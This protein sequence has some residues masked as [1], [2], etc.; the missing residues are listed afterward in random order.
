MQ[1]STTIGYILIL[2][3]FVAYFYFN[4]K[5]LEEIEQDQAQ[6]EQ[7]DTAGNK[8]D[9]I[10]VEELN[11]S[12]AELA[13]ENRVEKSF[14]I[15]NDK[16]SLEVLNY[17]GKP[18]KVELKEFKRYDST[19]LILFEKGQN[20]FNF[21]IPLANGDLIKTEDLDFNLIENTTTGDEHKLVVRAKVDSLRSIT[22][23]YILKDK[24]YDIDYSV[25]FKGFASIISPKSKYIEL[26]WATKVQAQE[27]SL[28]EERNT[29]TVYYK[30][31][32]EKGVDYLKET[33]EDDENLEA[34]VQWISFKQKFFNATLI[35]RE[36][37]REKGFKIE[38]K[39][40]KDESYIEDLSANLYLD[41]KGSET[42][43]YNWSL[44]YGPNHYQTLKKLD[45]G[46]QKIIP[47]GWGIFGWVNK[48]LVIPVF[49]WLEQYISN[50]GLIILCLTL[51]IKL[52]LV[53]PMFKTYLSSA[54]MRLLKPEL[55]AIKEKTG[56][57]MQKMQQEQMKLYKQAG[58]SP[59][60]G[61]LPQLVQLPI[62]FAMFRFFPAS[63]ELRQEKLWWADDLSTYDSIWDFPGGFE[64]PFYGDHV[65]LFTLL[66]TIVT[67]IYTYMNS[68]QTAGMSGPM[69]YVM[70]LMPIMFLGFFNNYSAALSFYYF[71]STCITMLQNVIIRKFFIDEDKL[72][73][74]LQENKKKKVSVKKSGLQKRLEEMAKKRGVDPYKKPAPKK[75]K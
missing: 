48:G 29:T 34:D 72:H 58:V 2:G 23:T 41:V 5:T 6:I 74:Q 16:L 15:E 39:E 44:Y 49:N 55:D 37:F 56:G 61:C 12:S 25:D 24:K 57:D 64:I 66:M 50:Y 68:Q 73:K 26:L 65:S 71:L 33:S 59:L 27:R 38:T 22:Q 11:L 1:K 47:L 9:T 51:L 28:E 21:S 63:I 52:L 7:Q 18:N 62:L 4:K 40:A 42:E 14:T 17:G 75:K 3:L 32:S 31:T 43:H 35:Q 60:G 45:V 54:K 36:G 69:K 53:V 30:Y 67:L 13:A 10:K 46:A 20:T 19:D 8:S 70:Y